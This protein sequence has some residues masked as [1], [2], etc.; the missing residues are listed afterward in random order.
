MK[1]VRII[2]T[3]LLILAVAFV[4][5]LGVSRY[6][7]W[8]KPEVLSLVPGTPLAYIAACD[9]DKTISAVEESEFAEQFA[10]SPLWSDIKSS[11]LGRQVHLQKLAWDI[12]WENYVGAEPL[13]LDDI[14]Q[15]VKRDALLAFYGG[16][17]F[18]LI[19]AVDLL[20]LLNITWGDT[21]EMLVSRYGFVMEEY[22]GVKLLSVK[23]L[24]QEFSYGFIGRVGLLGSNKSLLK[25][26]IDMHKDREQGLAAEPGFREL[27]VDMPESDLSFY[28]NVAKSFEAYSNIDP[29]LRYILPIAEHINACVGAVSGQGGNIRFDVRASHTLSLQH[30]AGGNSLE[31]GVFVPASSMVFAS[32]HIIEPGLPFEA[33]RASL[34]VDLRVVESKLVPVLR[35]GVTI[36]FLEPKVKEFQ[37]L[38]PAML[39]LQVKDRSTAETT[40]ED[41]KNSMKMGGKQLEFAQETYENI[42][43]NLT[44]LPIGM[45]ISLDAGYAFMGDDLL[46][47]AT[48]V[49]ALKSVVDVSLEKQPSLMEEKQYTHVLAPILDGSDGQVFMNLVSVAAITKQA[50]RLYAWRSKLVGDRDAEQM[51]TMLYQNAFL[52]ESWKYMGATLNSDDGKINVKLVLDAGY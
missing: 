9:L 51:A 34:G 23:I 27:I 30:V 21:E 52:L 49:P 13:K 45:G 10:K 38:P 43:I 28:V 50:A 15:L 24:G 31:D 5:L 2:L 6:L 36:A 47:L 25:A 20:A 12:Y 26:A 8:P 29:R 19:S 33:L 14:L 7:I 37:L 35:D 11:R 39:F 46:V 44:K 17:D 41:I 22:K 48:D 40:L 3:I 42:P 1:A 4:I 16:T 32:S 18:L